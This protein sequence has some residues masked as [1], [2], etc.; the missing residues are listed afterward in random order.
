MAL[1][2]SDDQQTLRGMFDDMKQQVTLLF[3]TQTFDCETCDETKRI[4]AELTEVTDRIVVE[5]V[6][7]VL[8]KERAAAYG[9]DRA[10]SLV[11]L[12]G[13]EDTRI[14]FLGAPAGYD[15]MAMVDAIL[16]VSGA[17]DTELSK[18]SVA[19]VSAV[20]EPTAIQIFVTP[21]CVYCPRAVALANRMA[22]LNP[23]ITAS[24]VVAT[25]FYELAREFRVTGVPKTVVNGSIEV[26][27]A[28]PEPEYVR[29]L[30]GIT[31]E[32][33]PG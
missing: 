26:L 22:F 29:A 7:L 14:R 20:T 25:E 28:L 30:L 21:T 32:A 31:D 33:V 8:D 17:S 3:F 4:L 16:A 6:N 11:L 1:L 12:T 9:I 24:T 13:G 23:N 18:D 27:G 10:P 19:L 15:F 5:E 2:S